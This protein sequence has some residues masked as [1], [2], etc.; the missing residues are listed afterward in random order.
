[1]IIG[2]VS[3]LTPPPLTVRPVSPR[4]PPLPPNFNT[5]ED[6]TKT[7]LPPSIPLPPTPGKE[8]VLLQEEIVPMNNCSSRVI[9]SP[10]DTLPVSDVAK[11][12]ILRTD[13]MPS[14]KSR[15]YDSSPP[16]PPNLPMDEPPLP[17]EIEIRTE[18]TPPPPPPDSSFSKPASPLTSPIG[19]SPDDMEEPIR[20]QSGS[21]SSHSVMASDLRTP[22]QMQSQYNRAAISDP[23]AAYNQV[24]TQ[25]SVSASDISDTDLPEASGTM[26]EDNEI[27]NASMARKESPHEDDLEALEK[28]KADLQAQ[29]AATNIG[30]ESAVPMDDSDGEVHTDDSNDYIKR[31]REIASGSKLQTKVNDNLSVSRQITGQ[32]KACDSSM[33]PISSEGP[34]PEPPKEKPEVEDDTVVPD[35][36]G[37]EK[38]KHRRKDSSDDDDEPKERE[39]SHQASEHL[40]DTSMKANVCSQ[41]KENTSSSEKSTQPEG[42]KERRHSSS[43]R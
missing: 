29:L 39:R 3:P 2:N 41:T 13:D 38:I 6:V 19:S 26:S 9:K 14:E 4:T 31:F 22:R 5:H 23:G 37:V 40:L 43:S 15:T 32:T 28:A 10:S 27:E 11:I 30:D 42:S 24:E 16:V 34:T 20:E 36:H 1:M 18:H 17:P 33:S 25:S 12:D 7:T 21:Y 35:D 8:E